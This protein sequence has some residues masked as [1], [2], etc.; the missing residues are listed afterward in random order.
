MQSRQHLP[1]RALLLLTARSYR[2]QPFIEAAERLDIEVVKA[3]DMHRQLAEYW[4]HPL[5]ID[6]GKPV[7]AVEAIAAFA[8]EKPLG[9]I[10]AV[11]DSGSVVAAKASQHLGLP[12]NSPEAAEAPRRAAREQTRSARMIPILTRRSSPGT[13]HRGNAASART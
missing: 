10:I 2:A 13:P 12:H 4:N 3:V 7:E 11:D 9:A 6:Y 1:R 8:V 5:G